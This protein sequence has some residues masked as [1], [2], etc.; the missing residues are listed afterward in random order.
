MTELKYA[1]IHQYGGLTH[2][3]ITIQSKKFFWA[4]WFETKNDMWKA[5]AL[6][7]VGS[8]LNVHIPPRPYL[9]FQQEDIDWMMG[10]LGNAIIVER[11]AA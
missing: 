2:P 1:R 10:V 8:K 11:E 5:M 4:M 3:T 7:A 9:L 6:K